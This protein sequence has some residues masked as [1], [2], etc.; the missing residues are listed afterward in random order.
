[1]ATDFSAELRG[2]ILPG[3][4]LTIRPDLGFAA[5]GNGRVDRQQ[6]CRFSDIGPSSSAVL[7]A[8]KEGIESQRAAVG[9][10]LIFIGVAELLLSPHLH[11]EIL[12]HSIT[13]VIQGLFLSRGIRCDD[14]RRGFLNSKNACMK[15]QGSLVVIENGRRS[16]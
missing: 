6:G 1:M 2:K 9:F 13:I 10:E 5:A 12:M 3:S 14:M 15:R 8:T 11:T 16:P 7:T 4:R